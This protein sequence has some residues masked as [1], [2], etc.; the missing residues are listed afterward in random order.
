M[1]EVLLNVKVLKTLRHNNIYFLDGSFTF[2]QYIYFQKILCYSTNTIDI[3]SSTVVNNE[4]KDF[5]PSAGDQP[6]LSKNSQKEPQLKLVEPNH[7]FPLHTSTHIYRQ[8]L[9]TNVADI[10]IVINRFADNILIIVTDI[11]KPGT[12]FQMKRDQSKSIQNRGSTRGSDNLYSVELLLG[13][14]TPELI[15]TARYLA[16]SLNEEKP[17]LLTLGLKNPKT[18]LAPAPAKKLVAFIKDQLSPS[19]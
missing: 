14:E 13:A 5:F 3:M 2:F 16:Q 19:N 17:I 6:C 4:E 10:D 11:A 15:T 9:E 18:S 12:I 1:N 7:P 8:E